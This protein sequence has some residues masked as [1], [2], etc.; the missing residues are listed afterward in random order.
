[1]RYTRRVGSDVMEEAQS[2]ADTL[3]PQELAAG[4]EKAHTE[5]FYSKVLTAGWMALT[6]VMLWAMMEI[7]G[8]GAEE[9][10][11]WFTV[12]TIAILYSPF[13]VI[14]FAKKTLRTLEVATF[15]KILKKR[16]QLNAFK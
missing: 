6:F 4:Y 15:A 2:Q 5:H 16:D 1:M 13:V 11:F 7:S 10:Q 3:S 12:A 14:Y 8:W 9:H